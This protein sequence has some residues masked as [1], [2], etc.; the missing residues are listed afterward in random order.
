MDKTETETETETGAVAK[1]LSFIVST[2]VTCQQRGGYSLDEAVSIHAATTYFGTKVRTT[3]EDGRIGT[4]HLTFLVRML[5]KSQ[6]LGKLSLEEAWMAY[7]AI[8]IFSQKQ[9]DDGTN[10]AA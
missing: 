6:S 8:Q 5:E 3:D 4:Q 9:N 1:A 10:D 2:V 7:N